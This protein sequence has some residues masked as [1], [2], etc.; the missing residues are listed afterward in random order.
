M[1]IEERNSMKDKERIKQFLEN[2]MRSLCDDTCDNEITYTTLMEAINT[3]LKV[4]Y[5]Y[6][7]M[8]FDKEID[9]SDVVERLKTDSSVKL[10]GSGNSDNYLI[11]VD[12][13]IKIVKGWL[14]E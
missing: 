3:L 12:K 4:S 5:I 2:T 8:G 14:E 6:K 10:Y 9:T 7:N 1:T 11:P 13:A